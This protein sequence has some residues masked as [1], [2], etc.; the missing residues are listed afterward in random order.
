MLSF[1]LKFDVIS[2]FSDSLPSLV[3]TDTQDNENRVSPFIHTNPIK[4]LNIN[5]QDQ[6]KYTD[7][8][9]KEIIKWYDNSSNSNLG[10]IISVFIQK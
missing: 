1:S 5:L 10:R 2:R 8:T 9:T 3:F 4:Y 6:E 7:N